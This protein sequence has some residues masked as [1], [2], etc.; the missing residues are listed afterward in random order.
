MVAQLQKRRGMGVV[1]L[2][3]NHPDLTII[4][5][6]KCVLNNY[7]L[8]TASII[9]TQCGSSIIHIFVVKFI[10]LREY[11]YTIFISAFR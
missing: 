10:H 3:P 6:V 9:Y 11:Y 1:S 7:D 4:V 8:G 2:L 5:F